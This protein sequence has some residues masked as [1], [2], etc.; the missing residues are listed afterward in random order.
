MGKKHVFQKAKLAG[1]LAPL[2]CASYV[3]S[4]PIWSG[5]A[6]NAQHTALSNVM[7]DSLQTI[8]WS[9]PVDLQP[10]YSGNDLFIHYGSPLITAANTIVVPVKTGASDGFELNAIDASTGTSKWT[11]GTTD[12]TLPSHDWT[13]SYSPVITNTNR[14]YYAGAGGTLHYRDNADSA[15]PVSSGTISFAG[16]ANY[17]ANA[18]AFNSTVFVNT[19]LTADA[20]GDVYFGFRV[21]GTSPFGAGVTGGIA[22]IAPDGSATYATNLTLGAGIHST[23]MNCAPAIST[24]GSKVY[25][26][27]STAPSSVAGAG[28]LLELNSSTLATMNSVSLVDPHTHNA[29]WLPDDG[30]ASPTIGKDGDV[31]FG[32]LDESLNNHD[33]G[34][35][36]HFNS[37]LSTSKT[38]GAFGWDD[39]ASIVPAS[40]V[41]SYHGSSEYLLM[42]K[43]NNY[44]STGGNGVNKIAILDPNDTQT[45]P[46]TGATVMKEVLTIAGVTHDDEFPG[47][48]N[49]VREWCI[50]SAVVDPAT[51]S[52]LVNSEDG[53]L[54]RWNLSTNTFTESI[55]LTTGIGEAYTPTVIGADGAVY[56]INNATLFSVVPE[57]STAMVIAAS[58]SLLSLR[59]NRRDG[60]K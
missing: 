34:W 29:A 55:A 25:A 37:D 49:A 54:Y 39:S 5:Y 35:L 22:K 2:G 41:S 28:E 7:A 33:R 31:Y 30:T 8:R 26:A 40:M 44:A 9:T 14:V 24:D 6:G 48:P 23:T 19:P 21:Q 16:N 13:P 10:Q 59:R 50:N 56:A 4:A 53:V 57:P 38:P 17:A 27:F 43:Y 60:A 1:L 12:Y 36:L 46:V 45:D 47:N 15:G 3:L 18:A 51:D 11:T 52:V 32:V 42:T 20:S 58:L